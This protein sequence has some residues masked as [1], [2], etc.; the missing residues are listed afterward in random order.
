MEDHKHAEQKNLAN[1]WMLV[2]E[3]I[4]VYGS[5]ANNWSLTPIVRKGRPRGTEITDE[6][7]GLLLWVRSMEGLGRW[8]PDGGR[9]LIWQGNCSATKHPLWSRQVRVSLSV[10]NALQAP[11]EV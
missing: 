6:W 11:L 4:A 5:C 7:K 2:S 9:G 1:P 8:S 3:Q 10:M